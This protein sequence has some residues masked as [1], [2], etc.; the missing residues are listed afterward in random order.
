M[1]VTTPPIFTP[2]HTE[3]VSR[4][5][6]HESVNEETLTKIVQNNNWLHDARPIG[7]IIFV[8]VNQNGVEVPDPSMFQ[9][10]DGSEITHPDSPLRSIGVNTRFTPT[11]QD[12]YLRVSPNLSSNP[13]GGSQDHNLQHDHNTGGPSAAG[14]GLEK[15]GDRRY[16]VPHT[17]DIAQQYANPTYLD[18]PAYIKLIAYMKIR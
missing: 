3:E 8:Q 10:C 12:R 16:R 14:P 9:I 13:T 7:S 17:H 1:A 5:G 18:A 11:F 4:N 15:K 6:T 2:V